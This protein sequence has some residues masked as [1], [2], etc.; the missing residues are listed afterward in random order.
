MNAVTRRF[1]MLC[2]LIA[3]L[4]AAQSFA[5][6]FVVPPALWD[7]PRTG[8]AVL[9]QPV[10]RQA[11]AAAM[12]A[13]ESALVIHHAGDGEAAVQAEEL[14]AWLMALAIDASRIRLAG[15]RKPRE[16][17]VVEVVK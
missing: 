8:K 6:S 17:L 5:Q 7:R 12:A 1:A 3:A 11:V 9:E 2:T 16:P 14:R 4:P 13:P 15:D 10:L